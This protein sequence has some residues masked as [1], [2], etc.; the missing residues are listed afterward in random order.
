MAT[1]NTPPRPPAGECWT[2]DT[3]KMNVMKNQDAAFEIEN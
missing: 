2:E 1:D 3:G